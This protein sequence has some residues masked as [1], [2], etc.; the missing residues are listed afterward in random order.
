MGGDD[1]GLEVASR[2]PPYRRLGG[3]TRFDGAG[4]H[5]RSIGSRHLSGS[6][7]VPSAEPPA[8][9]LGQAANTGPGYHAVSTGVP[10]TQLDSDGIV[11]APQGSA[12]D[13]EGRCGIVRQ[14]HDRSSRSRRRHSRGQPRPFD[15]RK[16]DGRERDAQQANRGDRVDQCEHVGRNWTRCRKLM[17]TPIADTSMNSRSLISPAIFRYIDRHA[18]NACAATN[19]G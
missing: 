11:Q 14:P 7:R 6:A 3:G 16:R 2:W 4:Y 5:L 19:L 17:R 18:E 13:G 12:V 9:K 1:P 8:S 10:A 15:L